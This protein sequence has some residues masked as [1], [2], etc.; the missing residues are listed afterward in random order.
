MTTS[1]AMRRGAVWLKALKDYADDG[2]VVFALSIN[3]WAARAGLMEALA[4]LEPDLTTGWLADG[5]VVGLFDDDGVFAVGERYS[6][7][8]PEAA[9][10]YLMA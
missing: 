4:L 5:K 10:W 3:E 2:V 7:A 6:A 9:P 8:C 1:S